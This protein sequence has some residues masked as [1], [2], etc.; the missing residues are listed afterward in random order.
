MRFE[1]DHAK[2]AR[3]ISAHGVSLAHA[4]HLAW[5]EALVWLDERFHFDELRMVGLVPA[6]DR[7]FCVA[8]VDR[9]CVRRVI[10]LRPATRREVKHDVEACP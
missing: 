8:F 10:S 1:Y 3:I 4:E 7:L 6:G 5:D 9:C 2:D